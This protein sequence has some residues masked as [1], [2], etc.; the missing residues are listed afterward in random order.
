[1]ANSSQ[2][3]SARLRADPARASNS[4]S[5]APAA[6]QSL[7]QQVPANPLATPSDDPTARATTIITS[8][9]A[10]SRPAATFNNPRA[11]TPLFGS[12]YVRDAVFYCKA[13]ISQLKTIVASAPQHLRSH[14]PANPTKDT[15]LETVLSFRT[16]EALQARLNQRSPT[17]CLRELMD[18]TPSQLKAL[19]NSSPSQLAELMR[20]ALLAYIHLQPRDIPSA[21]H[22]KV[23]TV[24]SWQ[25]EAQK[26]A[27]ATPDIPP[28]LPLA[29]PS[30]N[31][32]D[33]APQLPTQR[34][35]HTEIPR[36][37]GNPRTLCTK[38]RLV[39]PK[40]ST[41]AVASG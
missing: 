31:Y 12:L 20:A 34:M 40:P 23:I 11:N 21:A 28:P 26:A 35:G 22:E 18:L 30:A 8:C 41:R 25:L 15:L 4:P 19:A 1:M 27:H 32:P 37:T 6:S 7:I 38:P 13:T 17:E 2:R 39:T 29:S 14:L 3:Q 16:D 33:L 24:L 10:R 5:S 9:P 36:Q